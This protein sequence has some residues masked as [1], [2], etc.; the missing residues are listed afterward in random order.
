MDQCLVL[1]ALQGTYQD[2]PAQLEA[3][4]GPLFFKGGNVGAPAPLMEGAAGGFLGLEHWREEAEHSP[5]PQKLP[6]G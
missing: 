4:G 1:G 3:A 5:Q 6:V 2:S